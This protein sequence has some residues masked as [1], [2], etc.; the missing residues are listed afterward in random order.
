MR[1]LFEK[2]L[3]C[4]ADSTKTFIVPTVYPDFG[5]QQTMV[6]ISYPVSLPG[7]SAAVFHGRGRRR[8]N[9]RPERY[10]SF[11]PAFFKKLV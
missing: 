1:Q 8:R 5:T 7:I 6:P 9:G 10:K 11:C 3:R 2:K 4:P